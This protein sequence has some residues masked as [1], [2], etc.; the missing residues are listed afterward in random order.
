M[1]YDKINKQIERNK[2]LICTRYNINRTQPQIMWC[3]A[4]HTEKTKQLL[5]SNNSEIEIA[6]TKLKKQAWDSA[7]AEI[8]IQY[9]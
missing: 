5:Q 1:Q 3:H 6:S 2:Q 4:L 8:E 9:I 7:Y